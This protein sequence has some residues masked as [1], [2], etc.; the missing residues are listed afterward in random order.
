MLSCP[1]PSRMR[2]TRNGC[3]SNCINPGRFALPIIGHP[4]QSGPHSVCLPFWCVYVA[5]AGLLICCLSLV[6]FACP[7]KTCHVWQPHDDDD[8]A[9]FL[10]CFCVFFIFREKLGTLSRERDSLTERKSF[11][12]HKQMKKRTPT[13]PRFYEQQH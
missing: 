1:W 8:D 7:F 10:F 6:A 4:N 13:T 2:A 11:I 12:K 5:A 3:A 9:Q